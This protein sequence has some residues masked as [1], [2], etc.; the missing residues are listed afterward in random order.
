MRLYF[1]FVLNTLS[2]LIFFILQLEY[3]FAQSKNYES[4]HKA[5]FLCSCHF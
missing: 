2:I 4:V 3:N 5:I 1:P